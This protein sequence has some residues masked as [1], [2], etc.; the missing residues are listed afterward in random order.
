MFTHKIKFFTEKANVTIQNNIVT[1]LDP[2]SD[3]KTCP[4]CDCNI[5]GNWKLRVN[6]VSEK[7]Q[8]KCPSINCDA[9]EVEELKW[10]SI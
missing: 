7:L 3:I 10:I 9:W 1:K 6:V 4:R 8:V 5:V 2:N